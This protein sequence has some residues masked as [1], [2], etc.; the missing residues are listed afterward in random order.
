MCTDGYRKGPDG[1]YRCQCDEVPEGRK[2][3]RVTF[4]W[5]FIDFFICWSNS[6]Q[7]LGQ[8]YFYY[9]SIFILIQSNDRQR[10]FF[11]RNGLE[12]KIMILWTDLYIHHFLA[13]TNCDHR[14]VISCCETFVWQTLQSRVNSTVPMVTAS[15]CSESRSATVPTN[16][17]GLQDASQ[18]DPHMLSIHQ[19]YRQVVHLQQSL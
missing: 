16:C 1:C 14:A 7:L 9:S 8:I 6:I 3:Y 12:L 19:L 4:K 17:L 15:T 18:N 13:L 10:M 11:V 2:N 5:N